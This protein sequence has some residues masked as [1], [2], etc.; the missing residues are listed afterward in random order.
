[1]NRGDD[2]T[3]LADWESGGV[4]AEV[5]QDVDGEK[6]D[7]PLNQEPGT[8][9]PEIEIDYEIERGKEERG[10]RDPEDMPGF[11]QGA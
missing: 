8:A 2:G 3:L 11:G 7:L 10:N 6:L 9:T 4:M 1:V 5:P